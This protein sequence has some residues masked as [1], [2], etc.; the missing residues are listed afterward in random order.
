M[1]KKSEDSD[2]ICMQVGDTLALGNTAAKEVTVCWDS[3]ASL[4]FD[5]LPY[6]LTTLATHMC[7]VNY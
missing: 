4:Q 5:L 6:C 3:C 1:Q 7:S 2:D